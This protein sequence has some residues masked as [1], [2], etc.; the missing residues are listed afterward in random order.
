MKK[1][2]S[3]P[4][5]FAD[6]AVLFA[7]YRPREVDTRRLLF[8]LGR[9]GLRGEGVGVV[10]AALVSGCAQRGVNVA[11]LKLVLVAP[12]QT[13][14]NQQQQRPPHGG[15]GSRN[16][17]AVL[18]NDLMAA[19][20]RHHRTIARLHARVAKR[21]ELIDEAVAVGPLRIKF[22][23][24]ADPNRVLD[25]VCERI[26]RHEKTTGQRMNGDAMGLPYWAELWESAT[27][28]GAWIAR[29]GG[30]IVKSKSVMDLGCG[31]GLSGTVAALMGARVLF[32]DIER[33][34][35]LFARLNGLRYGDVEAQ[36]VDWQKDDLGRRFDV[37]LGADVLYDRS[38]WPFLEPFFRKHL[39]PGGHILLGEPG[40]PSGEGFWEWITPRG[41]TLLRR[42]QPV[43]G[44]ASPVKI[45][46]L[47]NPSPPAAAGDKVTA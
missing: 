18:S 42:E 16:A 22:T 35:L 4:G 20:P 13:D 23:R 47:T 31:M 14:Q 30:A 21:Y 19:A 43:P 9:A 34:S 24:V 15:Q 36:R 17:P 10:A 1:H 29:D 3:R 37:I 5:H 39:A 38:Q 6:G 7:R 8:R 12:A 41:W 44:K 11:G 27:A 40:R 2:A 33:E 45:F 28:I 46:E 32:A 25:E 26:D